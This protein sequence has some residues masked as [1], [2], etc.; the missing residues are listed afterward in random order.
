MTE[1]KRRKIPQYQREDILFDSDRKCCICRESH[2]KVQIHHLDGDP[3]NNKTN[4]LAVLC[5]DHHDE[6]SSKGAIGCRLSP[7]VIK[8]YRDEWLKIIRNKRSQYLK[9]LSPDMNLHNALLDA[10]ACQEIIKT[11][12]QL[13]Q[14]EWS[15]KVPLLKS[16]YLYTAFDYGIPPK[17]RLMSALYN[18][19]SH[20]ARGMTEEVASLIEYLALEAL[21]I[22]SLVAP[23]RE[24][25][26][27]EQ[28]NALLS[29]I[30]TGYTL[31]YG[32]VVDLHNLRIVANGARI[33]WA[34]L[35]YAALN[36][37][38]DLQERAE[39]SFKMVIES[40]IRQKFSDATR[41]LEYM[42]ADALA[43]GDCQ[44]PEM[45]KDIFNK[46]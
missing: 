14:A 5:L 36:H 18:L 8:K 24:T 30:S 15:K 28:I 21:P 41:W 38:K 12:Q 19:S 35:R 40:S 1:K 17:A 34:V 43:F 2:K 6:A 23:A 37:S 3:E 9:R 44:I 29:A 20:T 31:A 42:Q 27:K 45:P 16:L 10:L 22:F 13:I 25:I 32:G 11:E 4:N 33:L 26:I 7:G 46:L 39:N